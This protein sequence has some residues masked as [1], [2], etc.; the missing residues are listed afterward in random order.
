MN[1]HQGTFGQPGNIGQRKIVG[2]DETDGPAR[3]KCTHDTLRPAAPVPRIRALEQLVQQKQQRAT[4]PCHY[5]EKLPQ[6]RDLRVEAR[7]ALVQRVVDPDAGTYLQLREP[8]DPG[9]NRRSSHGQDG[10]D[11]YCSQQRALAGHV[12]ATDQEYTSPACDIN[13]VAYRPS[14]RDQG[15]AQLLSLEARVTLCLEFRKRIGG[16][17]VCIGR[18]RHERLEFANGVY[19]APDYSS[20]DSPPRFR[21]ERDVECVHQRDDKERDRLIAPR[22]CKADDGAQTGDGLRG[23]AGMRAQPLSQF[24]Q[25][26]SRELLALDSQE[27]L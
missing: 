27:Q 14:G 10:V 4:A 6:S 25:R 12:G 19:P 11:S 1:I 23:L 18:Q 20:M 13:A 7:A 9:P 2:T 26:R 24:L 8:Q 17:L 22:A 5:I 21:D 3:C 16:M 15:M